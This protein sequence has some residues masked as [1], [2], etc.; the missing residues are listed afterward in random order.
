MSK[1]KAPAPPDP[2]QTANA[3]TQTNRQSAEYNA[4]LNRINTYSPLGSQEYSVTGRDPATGAPTYRQ[5]I[6]LTPEAQQLY[7]Q[8]LQQNLQF[9]NLAN[10]AMGRVGDA[11]GSPF[12]FGGVEDLRNQSQDALYSRNTEYLDPQFQKGEEALRTRMANQGIVEGSEAYSNAMQDFNQGRETAYRQA[13]NEA[14]G[15]AGNESNQMLAQALTLRNQPLNEFNALRSASPVAMPSF[16][17]TAQAGTNP[18]DISGNIYNSYAGNMGIYNT[19]AG[20]YNNLMSGLF[21][22]GAAGIMASDER[23]KE[24]IEHVGE[25][26]SGDPIYLFR[27]KGSDDPHVGVMAQEV[28]KKDPEAVIPINGVKHVNYGRVLARALEA[29]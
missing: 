28:E 7:D 17:G 9:G 1:P 10:D 3:Q 16:E 18:A 8:E 29:R 14:I 15:G 20:Q 27:Y 13:R 19:K 24:D 21:G 23:V 6:N 26:D 4:A 22:L 5:D 2:Y 11:V 12:S 25:L